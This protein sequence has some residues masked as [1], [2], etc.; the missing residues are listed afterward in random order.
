MCP[1]TLSHVRR[2]FDGLWRVVPQLLEWVLVLAVLAVLVLAV[3]AMAVGVPV[4]VVL[5][6]LM[7]ELEDPEV[8]PRPVCS[9]P[10]AGQLT[11]AGVVMCHCLEGVR[12]P[13]S[14]RQCYIPRCFLNKLVKSNFDQQLGVGTYGKLPPGCLAYAGRLGRAQQRLHASMDAH[15]HIR[16]C[17]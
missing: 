4:P 11:S 3:E 17:H 2:H 5:L 6:L 7:F 8:S 16:G 1:T 10:S 9:H 13:K 15:G 12:H 14:H